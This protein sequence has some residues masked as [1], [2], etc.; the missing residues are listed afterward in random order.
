MLSKT[1]GGA[2]SRDLISPSDDGIE[3]EK[4]HALRTLGAY[5]ELSLDMGGSLIVMRPH[6]QACAVYVGNPH[7]A[8]SD[9]QSCGTIRKA[10]AEKILGL[11]HAGVN[12]LEIDERPY[13]FTRS[14]MHLARHGAVVFAPT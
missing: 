14:F 13:R 8:E 12:Y 9:F 4:S 3:R 7:C 5:L 6:A 11:T 2:A 10:L 1:A